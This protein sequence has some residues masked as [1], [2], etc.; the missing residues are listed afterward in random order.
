MA[1]LRP[2]ALCGVALLLACPTPDGA[3]WG[4]VRG[5]EGPL[6]GATVRVQATHVSARTG[7]DGRFRFEALPE[8]AAPRL[9]ASAPGFF[10]GGGRLAV[11]GEEAELVLRPHPEADDPSY[12]F[13]SAFEANDEE[14]GCERCH[15]ELGL[16]FDGWRLDAHASSASNPRFLTL[17]SGTDVHGASSPPTRYF[18]H[19]DY[20]PA[21]L[22]PEVDRPFFGPGYRLD[23]PDSAGNCAACHAPAAAVD[24]WDGTDVRDLGGVEAEGVTC[25]FCH[26]VL[27][28]ELDPGTRRPL[29]G[30]PGVLSYGLLRPPE[31]E[32]LFSGPLDDAAQE[33]EGRGAS[34]HVPLLEESAFCAPCHSASFWGVRVYDSYGEWLDS[35]WSDPETGSTCQGCHM[36]ASGATRLARA[37]EGGLERAPETLSSHRMLGVTDAAFM[38]TAAELEVEVDVDG[39]VLV[40]RSSV[41]NRGTGHRLPSGSPLRQVLLVVDAVD[42][43]GEP[44]DHLAGPVLPAWAGSGGPDERRLAGRPGRGYARILRDT[45][46]GEA[47]TASFWRA[48]VEE[49]DSRLEPFAVDSVE[50]RFATLSGAA[51]VEVRLLFRRAF[52]GLADLKG[53]DDPDLVMARRVVAV[54]A[55]P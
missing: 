32:Q 19:P 26:K 41:A 8:G 53:W 52:A 34:V 28:V 31:G 54:G 44:L 22:P 13:V 14:H 35:P 49:S 29:D 27:A 30:R 17:Y 45:W 20:G 51:T 24:A 3:L 33:E 5:A 10:I 38:A 23:Y 16:P 36:P 50:H 40:V 39:G 6:A 37:A 15:S 18:Q 48:C 21:A 12:R 7:R 43:G 55:S 46:S 9:T 25:D 47:P 42:A 11:A 4:T 2:L 1:S